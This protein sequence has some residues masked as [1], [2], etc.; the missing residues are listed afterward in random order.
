MALLLLEGD[1]LSSPE[2]VAHLVDRGYTLQSA[3][4]LVGDNI[5]RW[6]VR[7]LGVAAALEQQSD[8]HRA[9]EVALELG[10]AWLAWDRRGKAALSA[11]RSGA[12]LALPPESS[13]VDLERAVATSMAV[14]AEG[15]L[16]L[17]AES[18]SYRATAVIEAGEDSI[19]EVM[20][21][22]LAMRSLQPDGSE[23]MMGLFG[24]GDLL[25]GHPTDPCHIELVAHA[26]AE[27]SVWTWEGLQPTIEFADKLR[28]SLVWLSGWSAMQVRLHVE[29]RISGMLSLVAGRFG[30]PT[31]SGWQMLGV[32]LT[33]QNLAEAVCAT[34]P[35][36][37][38][39]L[40]E[41]ESR[42]VVRFEGT[43]DYRR[44]FLRTDL[45]EATGREASI[46]A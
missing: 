5:E 36:V 21:G 28:K 45:V 32:R 40:L 15:N 30:S 19:V 31:E 17:G 11:Y 43:G 39:V 13:P 7:P 35:T 1:W 37:T 16:S 20:S 46:K 14:P 33:H 9:A 22:V 34:R 8:A 18:R 10:V 44:M 25:V 2:Y 42:D 41:M 3:S 38:K 26:H 6:R 12:I 29:D 24:P 27:V 4:G 23:V